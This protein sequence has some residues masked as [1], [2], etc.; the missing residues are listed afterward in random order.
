METKKENHYDQYDM[1]IEYRNGYK[2]G[3][4]AG[5]QDGKETYRAKD[6]KKDVY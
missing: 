3:Y 2:D 4:N 1:S 5:F 6:V